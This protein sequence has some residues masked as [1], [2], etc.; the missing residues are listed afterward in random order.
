MYYG[1]NDPSTSPTAMPS[2]SSKCAPY[3][4]G[5]R[6]TF[7][8]FLAHFETLA[9]DRVLTG[10]QRVEA[11]V[12]YMAPSV[13]E[14]LRSMD[15]FCSHDWPDYRQF[16]VEVFGTPRHLLA[17]QKLLSFVQDSSRK[18][19][20][21][22]DDVLQYYRQFSNLAAP[23]LHTRRLSE[24]ER[25]AAFWCGFHI[26]DRS[27][28]RPALLAKYPY[29]PDDDPF[30]FADVLSCARAA[31]AYHS[32]FPCWPQEE[33]YRPQKVRRDL[34]AAEHVAWDTYGFRLAPRAV[35][36]NEETAPSRHLSPS[37][38]ATDPRLPFSS[39]PLCSELHHTPET[40]PMPLTPPS[41][42]ILP[43]DSERPQLA[44]DVQPQNEPEP[45]ST[46]SDTQFPFP[47][48]PS[49]SDSEF[50][51]SAK[52]NQ[53]EP[54]SLSSVTP[55]SSTPFHTLSLAPLAGDI[56]EIASVS[57]AEL[58]ANLVR[59]PSTIG[60]L[61]LV[62]PASSNL[63]P[64]MLSPSPVLGHLELDSTPAST[65]N[66]DT[67]PLSSPERPPLSPSGI[68]LPLPPSLKL[69][70]SIPVSPHHLS[71][72]LT[73]PGLLKLSPNSPMTPTSP[74]P[75]G[76]TP[77]CSTSSGPGLAPVAN[78]PLPLPI[79]FTI[80]TPPGLLGLSPN[81]PITPPSL[82]PLEVTTFGPIPPSLEASLDLPVPPRSPPSL[83]PK[84]PLDLTPIGSQ[85][86]TPLESSPLAP[87]TQ[88]NCRI[89]T[90]V[91]SPFTPLQITPSC[92]PSLAG[93]HPAHVDFASPF[94]ISAI[95][96][97]D[98][99]KTLSTHAHE[100]WSKR[101]IFAGSLS[102][103]A[104]TRDVF[105]YRLQRGQ[106]TPR[107]PSF[108]FDPGGLVFALDPTHED[109]FR[110]NPRTRG[111]SLTASSTFVT[112][113]SRTLHQVKTVALVS[114]SAPMV[115]VFDNTN[116]SAPLRSPS[117]ARYPI[118]APLTSINYSPPHSSLLSLA[119]VPSCPSSF[120][121]AEESA[122]RHA[123][124]L[125]P[126]LL[127]RINLY[128]SPHHFL[129]HFSTFFL[130]FVSLSIVALTSVLQS[131]PASLSVR[132]SSTHTTRVD[133]PQRKS[134]P[135][136]SFIITHD[137]L[138][139]T[140]VQDHIL[141][142][143]SAETPAKLARRSL[144]GDSQDFDPPG[145]VRIA[146]AL[147]PQSCIFGVFGLGPASRGPAAIPVS[148]SHGVAPHY[149]PSRLPLPSRLVC[150]HTHT[151]SL[152]LVAFSPSLALPLVTM[153][154][155]RSYSPFKI[156]SS[157]SYTG[158]TTPR[159]VSPLS[160][161]IPFPSHRPSLLSLS[162]CQDHSSPALSHLQDAVGDR[163]GH[164]AVVGGL[165]SCVILSRPSLFSIL[166][167]PYIFTTPFHLDA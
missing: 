160:I 158:R 2:P 82:S 119:G 4:S 74:N 164:R 45:A 78:T 150:T 14:L 140:L 115:S 77:V 88:S 10:S 98:L 17:R 46:S 146:R 123:P 64:A 130:S 49:A 61:P 27:T 102:D 151:L 21:C 106:Y 47:S 86:S 72:V 100:F 11:I 50:A 120:P 56:P 163:A 111:T 97:S 35:A 166:V 15:E 37:Q 12:R 142:H 41:F 71:S 148:H 117:F 101:E 143:F 43:P 30:P 38:L 118:L 48:S 5:C 31:F 25:D 39:S 9:D 126:R 60:R 57:P 104:K 22:E 89:S 162:R 67:A 132:P 141:I 116:T 161:N 59:S 85:V 83:S 124:F 24:V 34:P 165:L 94:S 112:A 167:C 108:V 149:R 90:P 42:S 63:P 95:S 62:I 1:Y 127:H 54:V 70:L 32:P 29:Q 137:T 81:G 110:R 87:S 113:P 19:M 103:A 138:V 154:R 139:T 159:L 134:R 147:G 79:D 73:P 55:T 144:T 52:D 13:R 23:V 6:D 135:R 36:S 68:V 136:G 145:G 128:R 69:S 7:E 105:A 156:L 122:F 152:P 33:P 99:G 3:Y 114:R 40:A 92:S 66:S 16:L 26:K 58:P 155:R 157:P 91:D 131:L 28:L 125:D 8:D 153:D 44:T 121:L 76:V 65:V 53:P 84:R 109:V 93:P 80:L 18:R 75:L 133:D 107:L 96:V 51:R 129:L 20:L